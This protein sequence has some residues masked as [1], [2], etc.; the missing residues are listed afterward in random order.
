LSADTG[1]AIARARVRLIAT[2]DRQSTLIA[3]DARGGFEFRALVPG[4]Y[5]LVAAK[6]GFVQ[7]QFGQPRAFA[8][9]T[10]IE[11]AAGQV[12]ERADIHLMPGASID[13]RVFDEFGEPVTDAV[14]M[15]LRS[16]F[17]GGRKR[18]VNAGRVLTTND[19][20]EF[21]LFGLP[22]GTYYLSASLLG[23][24]NPGDGG[25]KVGYAPTYYPG[26]ADVAGAEPIAV[27]EGEQRAGIDVILTM[28][29]TAS[30]S[31]VAR[32]AEGRPFGSGTVTVLSSVGGF[33]MPVAAG[34]VLPDGS[35]KLTNVPPGHF[36]LLA[37]SGTGLAGARESATQEVSVA[38]DDVI[39][40][41]LTIPK[42]ATLSGLVAREPGESEPLAPAVQ[43]RVVSARPLDD[44]TDTGTLV[45][46]GANGGFHA[47]VKPGAMRIELAGA[48]PGWYLGRVWHGESDI[49][50][51]GLRL[52]AEE[53]AADVRVLLTRRTTTLAGTVVDSSGRPVRDYTVVAF[54]R[55]RDRWGFRSRHVAGA[56]PDQDGGFSIKGLPAGDYLIVALDYVEQGEGSDP[57]FLDSIRYKATGVIL[58]DAESRSVVLTLARR[59]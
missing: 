57:E 25:G 46:T 11:L 31:G 6:G 47:S 38:G 8:P 51:R 24:Q 59:P 36:T 39:G 53:S 32:D 48:P 45:R 9:G 20:G 44:L 37:A 13:G 15:T 1:A 19:R 42:P 49:T 40:V 52:G 55:D 16:Q 18:L 33:P 50:D 4:R 5:V 30:V 12:V 3:A 17:A 22:A 29:K 7:T 10:P 41:V 34:A 26:T 21:H 27:M 54:A 23:G 28:V 2:T 14:V 43:L 56:R 35:F 58:A